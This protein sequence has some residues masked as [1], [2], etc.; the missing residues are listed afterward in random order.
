MEL[1][2]ISISG[3]PTVRMG[4][5]GE[6]RS[7]RGSFATYHVDY[8]PETFEARG[9]MVKIVQRRRFLRAGEVKKFVVSPISEEYEQVCDILLP[10]A[11]ILHRSLYERLHEIEENNLF[12]LID[13]GEAIKALRDCKTLLASLLAA[14]QTVTKADAENMVTRLT[15]ILDPKPGDSV[16]VKEYGLQI[17]S[18]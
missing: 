6:D 5:S 14:D 1:T 10:Q 7:R 3:A 17:S 11:A 4:V 16:I 18:R 13:K 2:D 15:M 12:W 8:D 9:V